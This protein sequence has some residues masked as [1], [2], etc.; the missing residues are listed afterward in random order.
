MGVKGITLRENDEVVDLV[1]ASPDTRILSITKKG[2]GKV[3]AIE[4]YR[5]THRGG[6]GVINMKFHDDTA[7]EIIAVKAL[8]S[9]ENLLLASQHGH[10]IRIRSEDVRETGRAA[11]G[12]IV[13]KFEDETDEITSVAICDAED[14]EVGEQTLIVKDQN[15]GE[16]NEETEEEEEEEPTHIEIKGKGKE[17][18]KATEEEDEEEPEEDES[19]AHHSEDDD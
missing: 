1:V 14:E 12:V 3:S 11:K 8:V 10:L 2:Y 15:A 5:L 16:T 4:L 13:M 9:N 18:T 6:K 7:D 17:A 19:R